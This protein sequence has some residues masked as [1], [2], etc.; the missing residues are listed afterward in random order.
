VH[1]A[2]CDPRPDDGFGR[3][4]IASIE[5]VDRI[6]D[7]IDAAIVDT[8]GDRTLKDIVRSQAGN[9]AGAERRT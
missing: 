4:R 5:G 9:G 6:M 8:L 2:V 7:I 3:Q 1:D